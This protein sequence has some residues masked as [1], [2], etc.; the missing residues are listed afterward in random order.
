MRIELLEK[1]DKVLNVS[2]GRIV[3]RRKG[4]EVDIIYYEETEDG[5]R[6]L[7]KSVTIGF[8]SRIEKEIVDGVEITT[9]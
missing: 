6:V 8:K 7:D 5:I 4:G 1:G 2:E 9:F 3:I